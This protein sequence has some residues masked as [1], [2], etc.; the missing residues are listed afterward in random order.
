MFSSDVLPAPLG[1]MI[2][3]MRPRGTS[4]DTSW[5][6]VTPPNFLDTPSTTSWLSPSSAGARR[7][8][9]PAMTPPYS[10]S[11]VFSLRPSC[12]LRWANA[13]NPLKLEPIGQGTGHKGLGHGASYRLPHLRPRSHVG[14][15]RPRPHH[16]DL[17]LAR[18]VRHGG[19]SPAGGAAR[20]P[21]HQG[22]LLHAG[23]YDR[24]HAA[25]GDAL[26][27]GGPRARPSRL[28]PPPAG[29]P[30]ARGRRRGDCPRQRVD[31]AGERQF[32]ARLSL[33]RL[34]PLASFDR[35]LAEA[36]HPLRHLAD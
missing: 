8:D 30:V 31:Q 32:C 1:P 6:A 5:A 9:A 16:P 10:R 27:R 11:I 34:G 22:H 13:T 24:Q 7:A 28:D 29:Q 35:A 25:S 15:H 23:P 20:P 12:R 3:R 33:A 14:L 18:R 36:P 17:Y 2:D 4:S 19:H 21:R 26:C